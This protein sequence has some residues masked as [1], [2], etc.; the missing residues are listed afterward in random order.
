MREFVFQL[1]LSQRCTGRAKAGCFSTLI[2]WIYI[3]SG[4]VPH[5]GRARTN[6]GKRGHSFRTADDFSL[7]ELASAEKR[8]SFRF[9]LAQNRA[10]ISSPSVIAEG[11]LK[12]RTKG[13]SQRGSLCKELLPNVAVIIRSANNPGKRPSDDLTN[14]AT[15]PATPPATAAYIHVANLSARHLQG[16]SGPAGRPDT[17][18]AIYRCHTSDFVNVGRVKQSASANI[19][20]E[21]RLDSSQSQVVRAA[22]VIFVRKTGVPCKRILKSQ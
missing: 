3:R 14:H 7:S 1:A 19:A 8:A 4:V 17:T 16:L 5:L 15:P 11:G 20:H 22:G 6:R 10:I 9:Q 13:W 21:N 12:Q 18:S 2:G